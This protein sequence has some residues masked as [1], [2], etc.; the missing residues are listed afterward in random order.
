M[1]L[2]K[3]KRDLIFM[4]CG[5]SKTV[6]LKSQKQLDLIAEKCKKKN[7]DCRYFLQKKIRMNMRER[8][9]QK[10]SVPQALAISYSQ[11]KK[12]FPRCKFARKEI[13][14]PMRKSLSLS[15]MTVIKLRQK[16]KTMNCKGYSRMKKSELVSLIKSCKSKS[17]IRSPIRSIRKSPKLPVRIKVEKGGLAGY[18]LKLKLSDRKKVLD[19]LVQQHG[20]GNVV[21]KLNVLYIYNKNK[22]PA[23]ALKFK[24]DMKH[25]QVKYRPVK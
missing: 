5:K 20:W 24:E 15:S 13:D 8:G 22:Y 25:V 10:W 14:S 3:L 6:K 11:V 23:N 21:K 19:K 2:D 17:P 12:M 7:V 16:A 4:E 1:S 9:D 18:S